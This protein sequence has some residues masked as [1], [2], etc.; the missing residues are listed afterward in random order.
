MTNTTKTIV[1][2]LVLV[3]GL[4]VTF[5]HLYQKEKRTNVNLMETQKS[6]FIEI[7]SQRD[8]LIN[9]WI[10]TFDQIT[11]DINLIKEKENIIKFTGNN[12]LSKDKKTAVLNDIKLIQDI[13]ENNKKKIQSLTKQIKAAGGLIT[14]LQNKINSLDSVINQNKLDILTLNSVITK[15]NT[16]I[17]KL[18]SI[19]KD[20]NF[21][22]DEKNKVITDQIN[23]NN[24]AYITVGTFKTLKTKNVLAK[25]GGFLGIARKKDLTLKFPDNTFTQIDVTKTNTIDVNTKSAKLISQH[26]KDS[27]IFVYDKKLIKYI[28]ITDT[29]LFWKF[30]KYAV[31]EVK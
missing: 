22:I 18:D 25:S 5:N 21:T 31:V 17:V 2:A 27:Y 16:E 14:E 12:E 10:T 8:S 6:N 15:K 19:V 7:I 24:K 30:S 29:Y 28:E 4:G 11:K 13:I 20:R 26:P 23:E 1:I 3:V 9:D